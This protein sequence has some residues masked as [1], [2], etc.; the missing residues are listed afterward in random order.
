MK[1]N[2][3]RII[4][5]NLFYLIV[6]A[7]SNLILSK[8]TSIET[9]AAI[10]EYTLY[11]FTF[12]AIL[13]LGYAYGVYLEYGGKEL[14]KVSPEEI[15]RSLLTFIVFL[16]PVCSAIFIFGLIYHNVV[17]TVLGIGL[18]SWN[19]VS[20]Y[21]MLFQAVG[22]YK[23]YGKALN[24]SKVLT[25]VLNLF[26]I[27]VLR[28]DNPILYVGTIPLIDIVV[29][30]YMTYR[31]NKKLPIV[32]HMRFDFSC[33]KKYIKNGF[34]LMLGE[35][36]TRSF[37]SIDRWFVNILF[38][39]FEFA[40]YSFAVTME[41]MVNTFMTPITVSMYNHFCKKPPIQEIRRIKDTTLI[42]G[43][44]IIAAAFP[45][46]WILEVFITKYISANAVIFPLFAAQGISTIIRGIYVNK[47]KADGTQK[48]YLVQTIAML[49]LAVILNTAFY[50]VW[51]S[52][53]SF[54]L[55][56]LLTNI[57]WLI[58]C[59]YEAKELRFDW[60]SVAS[61]IILLAVYLFTGMFLNSIVGCL[62]YCAVGL[63]LG[64]TLMRSVFV[65]LCTNLLQTVTSKFKKA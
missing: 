39:T 22:D 57:I 48:K 49:V 51:K 25:F 2:L 30:I 28:T 44:V 10:K 40:M 7:G 23:E 31:V 20:Y 17:I 13:T 6:G 36:V 45:C 9:Y 62:V 52:I 54:A 15:G 61:M 50:L 35:F 19:F 63:L 8:F 14:S 59:E 34:V 65:P 21:Q 43:M 16:L 55:A 26:F 4:V 41:L 37:S 42:Y 58:W 18:I 32:R 47:Y 33:I 11:L 46:K 12:Y 53:I 5:A 56:T 3:F 1:K 29:A 38:H 64:L 24:I 27:F 60:R